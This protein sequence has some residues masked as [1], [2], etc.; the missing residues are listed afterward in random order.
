MYS[1]FRKP[2]KRAFQTRRG[3]RGVGAPP[4]KLKAGCGV[5]RD[6]S[7]FSLVF[8]RSLTVFKSFILFFSPGSAKNPGIGANKGQ[9]CIQHPQNRGMARWHP[10]RP[11]FR[12]LE[13]FM[14]CPEGGAPVRPHGT[15]RE[16]VLRGSTPASNPIGLR[17]GVS[18]YDGS[19]TGPNLRIRRAHFKDTAGFGVPTNDCNRTGTALRIRRAHFWDTTNNAPTQTPEKGSLHLRH[20]GAAFDAFAPPNSNPK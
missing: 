13:A 16:D 2:L 1:I 19:R 20:G 11:T 17:S 12:D 6:F 14:R 18:S 4:K 5:V 9:K 10:P 3:H 7:W 8:N 15:Q